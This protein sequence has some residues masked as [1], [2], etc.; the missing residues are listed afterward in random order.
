MEGRG[1]RKNAQY[2][3]GG[4]PGLKPGTYRVLGESQHA[5]EVVLTSLSLAT[6]RL[7]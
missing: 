7:G 2:T 3:C 1:W 5:T 6:D 4:G